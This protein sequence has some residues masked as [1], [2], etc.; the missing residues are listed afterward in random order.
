MMGSKDKKGHSTPRDGAATP[1]QPPPARSASPAT[2]SLPFQQPAPVPAP[3]PA[4]SRD[5]AAR[6]SVDSL[7]PPKKT[8]LWKSVKNA[9]HPSSSVD[10]SHSKIS[11]PLPDPA[12][13]RAQIVAP[14][15]K[16]ARPH[17]FANVATAAV[18]ANRDTGHSVA[19]ESPRGRIGE[20]SP[21]TL[22]P[23]DDSSHQSVDSHGKPKKSVSQHCYNCYHF[24]VF[25]VLFFIVDC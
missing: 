14:P 23:A 22:P 10:Y 20:A 18:A 12:A 11:A 25:V 13:S 3:A 7:H 21:Y 1:V 19:G 6:R 16:P 24:H 4:P 15:P 9:A 17:S 2:T 5:D 8:S